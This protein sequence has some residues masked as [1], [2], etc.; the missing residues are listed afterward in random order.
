MPTVYIGCAENSEWVN[1]YASIAGKY[2]RFGYSIESKRW[3]RNQEPEDAALIAQY[4]IQASEQ[5]RR[6]SRSE[7][8]DGD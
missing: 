5:T 4:V 3:A 2:V 8:D 7:D 6:E 1:V